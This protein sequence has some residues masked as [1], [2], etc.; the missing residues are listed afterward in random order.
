LNTGSL[1]KGKDADIVLIDLTRP[2][3]IPSRLDNIVENLIWAADGSE[4][5]TVVANG[6]VVK[7]DYRFTLLDFETI[8]K[9]VQL[10]SEML[11]DYM[12]A[13]KKITGT[14]AHK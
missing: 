13:A 9:D 8:V 4:V 5:K 1:E 2:N 10:L 12:M 7:L 3:L 6:K 11:T 14:G